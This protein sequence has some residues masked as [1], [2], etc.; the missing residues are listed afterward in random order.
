MSLSELF[1]YNYLKL[2]NLLIKCPTIIFSRLLSTIYLYSVTTDYSLSDS[3]SRNYLATKYMKFLRTLIY[4]TFF[5]VSI[6][7]SYLLISNLKIWLCKLIL[8]LFFDIQ[9]HDSLFRERKIKLKW[10]WLNRS[11][12][13]FL[14]EVHFPV[15]LI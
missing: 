4:S 1:Y 9:A 15:Y 13:L 6:E 12:F 11:I 7:L 5:W 8:V 2:E 3:F 10:G 14:S